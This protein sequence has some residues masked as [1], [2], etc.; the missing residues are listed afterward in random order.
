MQIKAAGLTHIGMKRGHNEDSFFIMQE[1]NL[2]VVADG[3][4]GHAS[5]EIASQMAVETVANFFKATS[6]DDEVTWPFKMDREHDYQE[7]RLSTGMKLGNLRIYEAA[8]REVRYR[9]MGTTMVSALFSDGDVIIGHVG[10]SRAYL[11]RN[12]EIRQITE[13]HS[14][15]NDYIKARKLTAE[16]IENFPHKNVI[17]RALG[18]KDSIAVDINRL[19]PEA[20]DVYLLCTD[21]LSG[22]VKDAD[23]AQIVAA[24]PIENAVGE[25]I[26]AANENGGNDNITVILIK[27]E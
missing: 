6:N 22:M 3:M 23:M 21:G 8:Q 5:G 25:L 17:V 27:A 15:L 24:N 18:M 26:K 19:S 13:D 1:E 10:D 20:G 11:I 14:L 12:G 9:G 7:N 4:G 2:F 16:E